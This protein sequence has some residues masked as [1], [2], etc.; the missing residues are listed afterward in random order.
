LDL[1]E[2]WNS[3]VTLAELLSEIRALMLDS[4]LFARL[5]PQQA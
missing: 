2:Q 1:S 4:D 5:E 3:A